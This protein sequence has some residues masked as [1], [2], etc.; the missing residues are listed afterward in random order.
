[1][2]GHG[3]FNAAES[4]VWFTVAATVYLRAPLSQRQRL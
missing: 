3:W 1:V 2:T 4:I